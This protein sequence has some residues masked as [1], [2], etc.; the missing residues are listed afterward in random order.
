MTSWMRTTP[1]SAHPP[2]CPPRAATLSPAPQAL[3]SPQP[4]TR[5]RKAPGIRCPCLT[6]TSAALEVSPVSPP[7]EPHHTPSSFLKMKLGG[8]RESHPGPCGF[9]SP[10]WLPTLSTFQ[11]TVVAQECPLSRGTWAQLDSPLTLG[12]PH[13]EIWTFRMEL[14]RMALCLTPLAPPSCSSFVSPAFA[15]SSFQLHHCSSTPHTSPLRR[16]ACQAGPSPVKMLFG[17]AQMHEK[18]LFA[19]IFQAGVTLILN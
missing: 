3:Q 18:F 17:F 4:G 7:W 5:K 10:P 1:H 12:L 13:F 2:L 16:E 14:F 8:R 19:V 15:L 9:S 6:A 11:N